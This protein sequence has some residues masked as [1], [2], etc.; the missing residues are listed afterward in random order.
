[1]CCLPRY[2]QAAGVELKPFTTNLPIYG[3]TREQDLEPPPGSI[4]VK[5]GWLAKWN[6]FG[7]SEPT[8]PPQEPPKDKPSSPDA[9]QK[10]EKSFWARWW[11]F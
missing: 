5:K 4:I 10:E 7:G 3:S 11:P 9:E 8:Q 6:P 1:M 2:A